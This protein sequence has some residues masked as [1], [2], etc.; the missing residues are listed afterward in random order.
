MSNISE[1]HQMCSGLYTY[2][3]TNTCVSTKKWYL[4]V[5]HSLFAERLSML[6]ILNASFAK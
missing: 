4:S 1:N 5:N 2:M 3:Y 6:N